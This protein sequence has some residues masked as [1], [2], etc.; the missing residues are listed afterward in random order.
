VPGIGIPFYMGH[1]RLQRLELSQLLEVEGGTPEWCMRILRHETGHAIDNAYRL[2]RKRRRQRLF[3]S[4]SQE[5][6]EHYTPKPY[7]RSFVY[8]LEPWYAQSHPDED[9]A[10][11][12]AIW[13]TPGL[14]WRQRYAEWPALKKV[15]YLDQL[16]LEIKDKPPLVT[17]R[18]QVDPL[19]R[20]RKT[21]RKHYEEKAALR[22]G[23]PDVY[24]RDLRRLFSDAPEYAAP[25]ASQ[26][27]RR[28]VKNATPSRCGPAS[29]STP[30]TR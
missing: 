24:D 28:S 17:T 18:R 9:F 11:T 19:N 5:Y 16:M 3:G 4:S 25:S 21:L 13:L 20:M 10:E 30:S 22:R 8:H 2:R 15:E 12:F 14:D 27:I 1:P 29:T 26:F 23:R 7:S 6:P